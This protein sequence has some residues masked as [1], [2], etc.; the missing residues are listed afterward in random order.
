MP[1]EIERKFLVK[2]E[3]WR[4]TAVGVRIAQGYLSQDPARTVRVRLAGDA[5]FL[6]IKGRTEGISRVEFEYGVPFQEAQ[7]L[8]KLCLPS[9]IDKTRYRVS[10]AGHIWE[11]DE[12]HGEN[13][14][15]IVAEVE[16]EDDSISP[17]LPE[18]IDVEVSSERRYFN[19]CLAV[20]PFS[21]W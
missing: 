16:L 2:G 14:G 8:L 15:L 10:Y 12:F 9:V 7:E 19:S 1:V 17:E 21:K 13:A 6:T 18:W 20:L 5:G 4:P 11:V 3:G